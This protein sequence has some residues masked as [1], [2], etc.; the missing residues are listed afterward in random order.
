MSDD[1]L[2]WLVSTGVGGV[3]G[4]IALWQIDRLRRDLATVPDWL[5]A[6]HSRLSSLGADSMPPPDNEP[7]RRKKLQRIRTA[8]A[9]WPVRTKE[10]D[11]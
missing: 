8:P 1:I 7:R 11:P 10:S 5:A 3:V 4:G 6:I 2:K 9:G